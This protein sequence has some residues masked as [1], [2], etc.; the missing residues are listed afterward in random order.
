[1]ADFGGDGKACLCLRW[2]W[3]SAACLL[4]ANCANSN[5]V[6]RADPNSIALSTSA[7]PTQEQNTLVRDADRSFIKHVADVSHGRPV[8]V[9]ARP[10]ECPR[11]FCGCEASLYVFGE[12]RPNLNLASNWMR[13]FPRASPAPG[14][15]AVRNHHVFV[16]IS[17]VSGNDWLVHDGNSGH[18]LIREHVRSINGYIIVNPKSND[19]AAAKLALS[20]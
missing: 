2:L 8:V 9:G 10:R 12:V 16:L 11:L 14:M 4:L 3:L 20:Q 7:N 6:R 1:M 15:A 19:V 17:Q 13:E 5:T 18:G